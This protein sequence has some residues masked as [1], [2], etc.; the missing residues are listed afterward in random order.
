MRASELRMVVTGGAGFIGSHLVDR[1]VAEGHDTI[2]IDNL[3]RGRLE[4]LVEVRRGHRF[5]FVQ[6][7]IR[8]SDLL[9]RYFE[10]AHTVFH[11]AAQSR[12]MDASRDLDYT[13][14]T[15]VTGTFNV[16]RVAADCRVDRVVFASSREVYG[17]PIS[18][19]VDESHPLLPINVYGASKMAGEALCRSFR[20]ERGLQTTILRFANV[21]GPRDVDRLIPT[22]LDRIAAG[23]DLPVY[24]GTQILDLVW[25]DQAI[26]ALMRA[27]PIS[28][29]GSAINVASGT[30]TRILDLARRIARIAGSRSRVVLMPAREQEVT[31][32]VGST[33][34]MR[35]ILG[36]QPLSDP[37]MHLE[38]LL[39]TDQPA[40]LAL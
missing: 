25:I 2:A 19:P 34:R 11:L 23:D 26:E 12:V 9:R 35:E 24:G 17:D 6:G 5:E 16:L 18:V 36:V 13:F 22:W 27:W 30:G 33:Q 15:N 39:P 7:D 20:R 40:I 4:N 1:L 3:H 14:A 38:Q 37:L 29:P 8:D 28:V 31:R 10:G 21:Y 32:Y